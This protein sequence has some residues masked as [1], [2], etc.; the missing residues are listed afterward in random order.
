MIDS[1]IL[2]GTHHLKIVMKKWAETQVWTEWY[3]NRETERIEGNL[4]NANKI[5]KLNCNISS[6]FP[7]PE[8]A[9]AITLHSSLV[10][11]KGE[12]KKE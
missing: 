2:L 6:H 3:K 10:F 11:N 8:S 5:T 1:L 12:Q 4:K 7:D 9:H